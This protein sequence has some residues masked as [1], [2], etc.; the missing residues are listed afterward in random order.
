MWH[1]DLNGCVTILQRGA[2]DMRS[3]VLVKEDDGDADARGSSKGGNYSSESY[4]ET[5]SL[6]AM[7]VAGF[8]AVAAS[9]GTMK[10]SSLWS[11][12][13][14]NLLR[15][16]DFAAAEKASEGAAPQL[17]A[18]VAY[19]RAVLVFLQNV[20]S[21]AEESGGFRKTIQDETLSLCD[22]VG[23]ACRFLSRAD[24]YAF[25]D[26][27][28]K[29]CNELGSLDGLLITGL[30]KRGIG[31]LQSYLDR[32]ADVQTVALVSCRVVLPAEWTFERQKCLE[33]LESYRILLN[34][35]Q[36]WNSRASFDVGRLNHLRNLNQGGPA[37]AG[38][39]QYGVGAGKRHQP[40]QKS[41][42]QASSNSNVAT[43]PQLWARCNY[44]NEALPLSKLRRQEGIANNWLSRQKPVLTCCP[45][46]K[47]PLPRCSICLLSLGCLNPYM[48]LQRER[49]QYHPPPRSGA[50][51]MQGGMEDLSGLAN[52]PFATWFSWCMRC[53]VSL[54]TRDSSSCRLF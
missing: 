34:G 15:R 27:A 41:R 53:K 19:L 40:P 43:P 37:H 30:D 3:L 25:L 36:M 4:S 5:L 29:K 35:L 39:R 31:L 49:N 48:E 9:D 21:E 54:P 13:C 24:L 47:K 46:C 16:P 38:G 10:T 18:G 33:W 20:G 32:S 28:V 22:R 52:V 1:G 26:A 2:E 14:A 12:A 17:P 6:V 45:Q 51:V 44:C 23:F 42:I 11:S 8:T 50:P 7:C